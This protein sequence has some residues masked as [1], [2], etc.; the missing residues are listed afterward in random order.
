MENVTEQVDV[1]SLG[2]EYK[3]AVIG[4]LIVIF[5]FM[6]TMW[7]I[8]QNKNKDSC[9]WD[10]PLGMPEGSVRALIAL[11]FIFIVLLYGSKT[12][13]WFLGILGTIIGFY[14]GERVGESKNGLSQKKE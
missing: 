9:W 1:F 11:L 8:G 12:P 14:F 7:I 2:I 4:S 13:E 6:A 3:Y 5:I 10:H